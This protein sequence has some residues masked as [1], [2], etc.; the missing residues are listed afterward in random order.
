MTGYTKGLTRLG[1]LL[2]GLFLMAPVGFAQ[3]CQVFEREM[4]T[5][6]MNHEAQTPVPK[7]ELERI[8]ARCPE[9]TRKMLLI[10]YFFRAVDAYQSPDLTDLEAYQQ[11]VSFYNRSAENFLLLTNYE[12][13]D[14][15]F[16]TFYSRAAEFETAIQDLAYDAGLNSRYSNPSNTPVTIVSGYAAQTNYTS[17]N[18]STRGG[19]SG[20][21]EPAPTQHSYEVDWSRENVLLPSRTDI[22]STRSTARMASSGHRDW[23]L[24]NDSGFRGNN[25]MTQRTGSN[26][27]T[28]Y[29]PTRRIDSYT[30]VQLVGSLNHIDPVG[31]L[32]FSRSAANP[33]N[34]A[35]MRTNNGVT[36]SATPTPNPNELWSYKYVTQAY[37]S[38]ANARTRGGDEAAPVTEGVNVNPTIFV[39]VGNRIPLT[40]RPGKSS[41]E[42]STLTYGEAV[43]RIS[44]VAPSFQQGEQYV[45]VQTING[46]VGWLPKAMLVEDGRVAVVVYPV[47]ATT[48]EGESVPFFPGEPIVLAKYQH[49]Q[50]LVIGENGTKTGWVR[51]LAALSISEEDMEIADMIRTAMSHTS[52]YARRASL[53]DL[54][55]HP[56]YSQSPLA[57]Y[58]DRLVMEEAQKQ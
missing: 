24:S 6:F 52:I 2:S 54:Q 15:F 29:Q 22:E 28:P 34:R 47:P 35:S 13:E 48:S 33:A 20:Y 31:Y 43:Y 58:V 32:R 53:L 7:Q 14:P 45:Q 36:R 25:S 11:A 55:R 30:G 51:D 27:R 9:P 46:Q 10:Y 50:A 26:A 17:A 21:R 8:R 3:N 57:E 23:E 5:L 16:E 4:E 41:P 37:G 18:A 44:N 42:I 12:L 19:R 39:N 40:N 49:E 1:L 38:S 56:Y